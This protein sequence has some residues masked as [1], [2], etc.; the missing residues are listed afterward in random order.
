MLT[1]QQ[2]AN[3]KDYLDV[4]ACIQAGIPL[5]Q[6]LS[7]AWGIFGVKFQ[8]MITLKALSCYAEGDLGELPKHI[9]SGL[10]Q[11][12]GEVRL[13]EVSPMAVM[14]GGLLP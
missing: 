12:A 3:A 11:A 10:I 14:A 13:E 4:W 9:Q 5:Q 6:M 7:A 1:L 8:P 2:R